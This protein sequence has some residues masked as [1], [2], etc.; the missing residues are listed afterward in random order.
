MRKL[1]VISMLLV[2]CAGLGY[3]QP[4]PENSASAKHRTARR[5]RRSRRTSWKRKGQ[6]HIQPDRA[7]E[8]PEAL[9]REKYLNGAPSG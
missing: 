3:A 2:F 8:I 9:V 6:Q 7:L 1:F 4:V 5:H